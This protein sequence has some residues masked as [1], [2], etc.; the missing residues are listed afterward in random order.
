[1]TNNS[2]FST[3]VETIRINDGKAEHL[4][5]HS[6]RMER[7]M[8]HFYPQ[9]PAL[10]CKQL[11]D[12][13]YNNVC[14]GE[15]GIMK[16]RIVYGKKLEGITVEPYRVREV[17]S[18]RLVDGKD[19]DYSFKSTDRTPLAQLFA[20]RGEADDV[21]IVKDGMLTDTSIGNIA[22]LINGQWLTPASPLLEGTRRAALLKEKVV[23]EAVLTT[24]DLERAESAMVFNAM[25]PWGRIE[26]SRENL[27]Q[28]LTDKPTESITRKD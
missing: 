20:E 14:P 23:A 25:I 19:I 1:M 17:K 27:G 7:T 28:S 5:L 13:I 6:A 3:F 22:L 9:A 8:R 21:L 10:N 15:S 11:E 18:L 12:F 24:S 4:D 26:V 2:P 16:C